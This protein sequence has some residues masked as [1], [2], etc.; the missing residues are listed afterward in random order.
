MELLSPVRAIILIAVRTLEE[1]DDA[2]RGKQ[3]RTLV[4]V[5]SAALIQRVAPGP[6][7]VPG[8]LATCRRPRLLPLHVKRGRRRF[9][10][11]AEML[12]RGASRPG[13]REQIAIYSREGSKLEEQREQKRLVRLVVRSTRA[14][15]KIL[16]LASSSQRVSK[17]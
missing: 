4:D 16:L 9:E 15:P 6:P 5:E 17:R 2:R 7:A 1:V 14:S 11:V 8:S 12:D 10:T 3:T 13:H